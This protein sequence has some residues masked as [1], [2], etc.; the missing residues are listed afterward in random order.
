MNPLFPGNNGI[1]EVGGGRDVITAQ[2]THILYFNGFHFGYC[3]IRGKISMDSV[4][5]SIYTFNRIGKNHE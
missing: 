4:D 3:V 2:E 1:K 5:L